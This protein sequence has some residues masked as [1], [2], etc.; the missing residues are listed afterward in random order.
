MNPILKHALIGAATGGITDAVIGAGG[1]I[2]SKEYK[3]LR[4]NDPKRA[5]NM[6]AHSAGV[7]LTAGAAAG[8][9]E[10]VFHAVDWK[11]VKNTMGNWKKGVVGKVLR[12]AAGFNGDVNYIYDFIKESHNL[13]KTASTGMT[14][15]LASLGGVGVVGGVMAEKAKADLLIDPRF[16]DLRGR[17]REEYRNAQMTS[18]FLDGALK[19]GAGAPIVVEFLLRKGRKI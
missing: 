15:A 18:G 8:A 11:K 2:T 6:L 7:G 12:K 13:N 3:G 5:A 17:K 16:R 10:G 4:K 19:G 1:S 14:A 9:G